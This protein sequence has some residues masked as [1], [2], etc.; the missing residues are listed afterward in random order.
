MKSAEF[1][2]SNLLEGD[3][4][5]FKEELQACQHL[6]IDSE[7][8]EGRHRVLNFTMSNLDNSLNI[9]KLD[10]VFK[11]LKSA[12]KV[13]HAFG[14]VLKNFEDGSSGY[15]HA[16]ENKTVME[17]TKLRCTPENITNLK[18]KLQ[19]M[20]IVDLCTRKR[21]NTKWKF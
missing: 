18:E 7:L 14:F 4:A 19:K 11:G 20:D 17:R 21:A 12:A 10:L 15:F 1:D 13:N 6:L 9:R 16:H 8:E 3:D 5:D 2:V